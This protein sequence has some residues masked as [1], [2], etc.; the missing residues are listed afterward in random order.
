VRVEALIGFS[1]F[2]LAMG[3]VNVLN[4]WVLRSAA[5]AAYAAVML[6]MVGLE[7]YSIPQ[8]VYGGSALHAFLISCYLSSVVL[9]AFTLLR[10][11]RYDRIAA[12]VT[13]GILA[14]NVVLVFVEDL[15]PA[16]R[17]SRFY[18]IDQ[19]ALDALIVALI[20]LGARAISHEGRIAGIYLAGLLGPA[21]GLVVDDLATNAVIQ[22]S[23]W[24]IFTFELGVAWEASFF[25]YAVALRNRGV[26]SERD[27]FERL[28][29][30]DGLTGVANRR[31]FD[32]TLDR[33]W[34]VARRARVPFAVAMIDIDH[35]KRLNDT[36][37]HQVG[38]ECLRRVAALCSSILRR[39]GDCFARYGGEE[40]AAILVNVDIDHA[41]VLAEA[42]RRTV[43]RDGGI[44]ISIG[45]AACVPQLGDTA[46]SL[47]ARAD[48]ALYQAKNEGRNLVRAA[49][50]VAAPV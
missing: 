47:I 12:Q 43:E 1:G 39:A 14:L 6:V 29:Y 40:F 30:V 25:A 13:I 46:A 17:G 33:M 24:F 26:Q 22:H 18:V 48:Y 27:R 9:F 21:V 15:S 34:G 10:T 31:T 16:W 44:T 42:M 23:L 3:W 41:L 37:G 4:A 2:F 7:A 45:V 5:S 36:R 8:G 32:E 28:A 38:D 35:F 20:A 11:L 49:P 19:L 50:E